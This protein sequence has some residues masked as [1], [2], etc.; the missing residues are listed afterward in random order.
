M[1]V[2]DIVGFILIVIAL[3]AAIWLLHRSESKTKN[4]WKLAAYNLL[5]EKNPDPQKVKETV[6]FLRIYGGRFRKDPEFTQ[7]DILLCDLYR[8]T[9]KPNT[10]EKKTKK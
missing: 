2:L 3:V 8:E 6:K 7:L 5:E 10:A 1:S 4:K 9:N